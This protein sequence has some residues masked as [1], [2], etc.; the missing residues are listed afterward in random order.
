MAFGA[1][2]RQLRQERGYSLTDLSM[3]AYYSKGHLSKI[4]NGQH[5]PSLEYAWQLDTVLNADGALVSELPGYG[6]EPEAAAED[7]KPPPPP[8]GLP[9]QPPNFVGR[10]AELEILKSGLAAMP[11]VASQPGLWMIDGLPGV[12]KTA[13]AVR[14][15]ASLA[16]RFSDGVLFIDLHGYTGST[17]PLTPSEALGRLL[18]RLGLPVPDE[19]DERAAL[20]R[21]HLAERRFLVVADN[22]LHADQVRPLIPATAASRL[23][24]TS[25]ALLASLDGVFSLTLPPLAQEEG[26][27]LL[28][29]LTTPRTATARVAGGAPA[30]IRRGSPHAEAIVRACGRLP[31]A[32]TIAAARL[33]A[34]TGP[35]DLLAAFAG[36]TGPLNEM[37]DGE[38]SVAT[39]FSA[40]YQSLPADV[41]GTFARLGLSLGED[42]TADH[43]M[44]LDGVDRATAVRR[45]ERLIA[46]RLVEPDAAGRLRCHDLVRSWARQL[47]AEL[48]VEAARAAVERL[49][50]WA[51]DRT[52]QADAVLEPHRYRP[53]LRSSPY[54]RPLRAVTGMADAAAWLR[55]EHGSLVAACRAAYEWGLD[56]LCWQLAYFLRSHFFLTKDYDDWLGTHLVALAAARR[57]GER[58][59]EAMT[60]NNLGV[61]LVELGRQGE[62]DEQFTTVLALPA[63][64]GLE[65]ARATAQ[66]HRSWLLFTQGDWAEAVRQ[67]EA[68]RQFFT[69]RG[70]DR[71]AAITLRGIALAEIE[72]GHFNQA[73]EHLKESLATFTD[74]D[75]KLNA[76][77]ARN[78]LGEAYLRMREADAAEKWLMTAARAAREYQSAHEEARAFRLL[79]EIALGR[80]DRDAALGYWRAALDHYEKMNA[81]EAAALTER[82]GLSQ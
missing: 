6:P 47:A 44:A 15:A 10:A 58:A 50:V 37:T 38:R 66:A 30:V 68:A 11:P 24:V 64:P 18:R 75:L 45:V 48:P 42:W 5:L 82:I 27:L 3:L 9:P 1:R 34:G 8:S 46:S 63:E 67:G 71:S 62:A 2:L 4:E 65:Y 13:L 36:L 14:V 55:A 7:G 77:M 33:R 32:L 79:G 43:V 73:I 25:R 56:E 72:L 26:E 28:S 23:L 12:G 41:Q 49:A 52:A 22:A 31:L 70:M 53:P 60:L 81:P 80:G 51:V 78:C 35:A 54:A 39:A 16:T 29:T 19:L 20:W 74:L 59:A 61:A 40:S 17:P 69:V 21:A 57:T 76:I